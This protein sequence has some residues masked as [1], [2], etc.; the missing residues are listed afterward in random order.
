MIGDC[1]VVLPTL[2]AESVQCVVTSPPYW[3]LRDYGV[4]GQLGLEPTPDAYVAAMVDVFRE[5]RRV[6]KS[7]G[8]LWLNLGDS[9]VC[10][11]GA[12]EN[13][14]GYR[15]A[16]LK[17]GRGNSQAVLRKKTLPWAVDPKSGV[18]RIRARPNRGVV[19]GLKHK[20]LAMIPAR[21]ALALQADGWWLRSKIVWHKPS[22]MPEPVTDRPTSAYEEVF[23]FA[24][25]RRYFY[26]AAAIAE[27]AVSDSPSGSK[28]RKSRADHGGVN[29]DRHQKFSVPWSDVGGTRNARNVWTIASQP[30]D[31]AHFAVMPPALAQKCILAGSRIGDTVLDPFMGSG[32]VGM[33]AESLGRHWLGCELSPDYERLIE[34]RTAQRGL[35][36]VST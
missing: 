3:G 25:S 13:K 26:D 22:P 15:G 33:V 4:A 24:R 8:T 6:L 20:D 31:G 18:E 9:Y 11:A 36:A 5:V 12:N 19:P 14:R 10:W 27:R 16:R 29:D 2:E 34:K 35:L 1:R 17:N 28:E 21:V 23:L 7:D 32:T 30:Y